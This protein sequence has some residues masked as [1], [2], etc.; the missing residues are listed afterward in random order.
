MLAILQQPAT[1]LPGRFVLAATE[2][3][4]M[5][6]FVAA[7]SDVT[8]KE[9][10]FVKCAKADFERLWPGWG[11]VEGDML[12]FYE[13]FGARVAGSEESILTAAELG[14]ALGGMKSIVDTIRDAIAERAQN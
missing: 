4:S 6:K 11:K 12:E 5:A 14:V 9:A 8:G 7:W 13:G 1:T 3:G 2:A 10:V